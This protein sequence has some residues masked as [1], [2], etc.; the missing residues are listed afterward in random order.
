MTNQ[1][2]IF[3]E[4]N[5]SKRVLFKLKTIKMKLAPK[6]NMKHQNITKQMERLYDNEVHCGEGGREDQFTSMTM[7]TSLKLS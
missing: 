7:S 2:H 3:R 1:Q 6:I 5:H 4:I